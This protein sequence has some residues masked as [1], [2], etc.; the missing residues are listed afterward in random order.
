MRYMLDTNILIYLIRNRPPQVA[1]RI[2]ALKPRDTLSMSF[3]SYAE[4]CKGAENSL[5]KTKTMR[6]L[7]DLTQQVEVNYELGTAICHHYAQQFIRLKQVGT[8]IGNNDLWIASHALASDM[9]LVTN[10]T[11]EFERIHGLRLQNW[12][13]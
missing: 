3:V 7:Q 9:T 8:P 4:L 12:A 11:R 10:N 13:N 6:L 5:Q 1:K 2:N